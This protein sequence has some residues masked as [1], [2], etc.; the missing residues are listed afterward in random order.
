M[1]EQLSGQ[2]VLSSIL[3][4]EDTTGTVATFS[5]AN[6]NDV[7]GE[8]T[9]TVNWGDGTTEVGTVTG[10]NG[11]FA[12]AVP[13]STHFY[14]DAGTDPITVTVTGPTAGSLAPTNLTYFLAI[15]G[16]NGGSTVAGHVGWFEVSSYDV[17]ALV[18][19]M[20]GSATFSPLTVTLDT[21]GLT[22]VL[23][24]LANG[25]V[26]PSV[27]LE[28]VT[29]TGQVAYD[30][31][32]GNV[33]VIDCENALGGDTLSLSYQQVALTTTAINSK[34][35]NSQTFSW[36][37]T[38]NSAASAPIPAPV[39]SGTAGG[40]PLSSLDYYLAIDGLK[41]DSTAIGHVGW[42]EVTSYDVGA[43]VAAL[44]GSATFSPLTV[45]LFRTP[46]TDVLG[47]LANG[48]VISSVRLEGVTR[49][50]SVNINPQA[51]YDL[52]LGHVTVSDYE[53][54]SGGDTL[55]LSYQQV[56]LTTR[57]FTSNGSLGNPQTFSW[58][59]TTN[60]AAGAPIPPP[61]PGSVNAITLPSGLTSFLAIDGL[62]GGS[63]DAQHVG[64]F[65]V[66]SYDVGA[67][68]AAMAGSATFSPL[69][70]TL[71]ATGLTGVL[72]DLARG[73]VIPSVRLEGVA[74]GGGTQPPAGGL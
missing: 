2:V 65:D 56:A 4:G 17:G 5:D 66:S 59:L 70:V 60:R 21:T 48:T 46:L 27:R 8:F 15:D 11:S 1:T 53:N 37:L 32:L 57:T 54:A 10:Q 35:G 73:T 72:A 14:A 6:T 61:V 12:V 22:G 39:P 74:G 52:T 34:L 13:G 44:A 63:T 33:T 50:G 71:N 30:L 64:W 25:T 24:D 9:A 29:S 67:L 36:D 68:V 69:T 26:I 45:T 16:L 7:A 55:S 58:D 51:V 49:A 31:T 40:T 41:G 62:N 20:A 23:A 47:D 19:A 3:E 38:T 28:G 43:L 42:F 18:A